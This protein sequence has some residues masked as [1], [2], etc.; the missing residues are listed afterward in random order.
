MAYKNH[1]RSPARPHFG[2]KYRS[3]LK[4]EFFIL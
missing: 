3:N 4:E 1:I 2:L